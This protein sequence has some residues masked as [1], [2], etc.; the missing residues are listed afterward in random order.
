METNV[1]LGFV[2]LFIFL[3]VWEIV[4][5]IRDSQ[6]LY[7]TLDSGAN[8]AIAVTSVSINIIF[9]GVVLFIFYNVHGLI[10]LIEADSGILYW[11][12]LFLL[13]DLTAYIFHF[14]GHKSRFFWASHVIHH[15]SNLYNFTTAIRVPLTNFF[16]RFWFYVPL[17]IVGYHPMDVL[18]LE[19]C[20]YLYN[21]YLHTRLF[22]KLGFLEYF[23][24]TPSH[25]RVHHGSNDKYID[26]N[27]GGILIVWDRLFGTFQ[28]EEEEVIYGIKNPLTTHNPLTII[29]HEWVDLYHDLN[30]TKGLFEKLRLVFGPPPEK[31]PKRTDSAQR[32][33]KACS[34]IQ[35]I[36]PRHSQSY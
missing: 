35:L 7:N 1:F 8:L 23:L 36:K 4:V 31:S 21:F 28:E 34:E 12:S 20:I 13:S 6:K 3:I 14:I 25:H 29:T 30:Q 5:S 18:F 9:R 11:F 27:F 22:G 32:C 2:I 15:S 10:P 24:N 19:T 33:N 16:Y 17:C 26:K